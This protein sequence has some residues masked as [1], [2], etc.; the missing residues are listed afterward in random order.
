M[1]IYEVVDNYPSRYD[2][3]LTGQEVLDIISLIEDEGKFTIDMKAFEASLFGSTGPMI[4]K[5]L[6]HY[7]HDIAWAL[8][9]SKKPVS[10]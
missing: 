10:S 6:L 4:D 9:H 2:K 1:K 5:T 7:C 8:E 3:G